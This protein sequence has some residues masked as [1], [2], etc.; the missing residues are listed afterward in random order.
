MEQMAS[1]SGLIFQS[2]TGGI[3]DC[4]HLQSFWATSCPL[5]GRPKMSH[6]RLLPTRLALE[7]GFYQSREGIGGMGLMKNVETYDGNIL[8]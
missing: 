5:K 3:Y 1:P 8:I 7:V 6:A 2:S 4:N